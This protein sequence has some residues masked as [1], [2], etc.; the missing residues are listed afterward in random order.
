MDIT[1]GFACCG[2]HQNLNRDEFAAHIPQR[3][4]GQDV[5]FSQQ[6]ALV[7]AC[8]GD[9]LRP[10]GRCYTEKINFFRPVHRLDLCCNELF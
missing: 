5:I 9:K 8:N 7:T 2:D 1:T 3:N 6:T 10:I 4:E